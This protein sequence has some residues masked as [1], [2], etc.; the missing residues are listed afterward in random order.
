MQ[1][2]AILVLGMISLMAPASLAQEAR[3]D[4]H[5]REVIGHVTPWTTGACIEDVNHEVYGGIYSQ[6]IF[7]ESFQ[8]PAPSPAPKGFT[9]YG[10]EGRVKAGEL[11][12]GAGDGPKLICDQAGF[13]EGEASVEVLLPDKGGGNAA[14]IVKVERPAIGA[15]RWIGYEVALD[16]AQ[17][18]LVLGRHR[19]NWEP[20]RTVPC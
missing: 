20:I 13:S 18:A 15:D 8:E 5:A 4:V 16:P 19:N 3:I 10:G 12:A 7:G 1:H 2:R 6:M 17:E 9:A 11:A 14:L